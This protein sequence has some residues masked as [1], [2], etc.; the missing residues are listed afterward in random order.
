MVSLGQVT[1]GLLSFNFAL[2]VGIRDLDK[3][4]FTKWFDFM[5]QLIFA[6]APAVY[7]LETSHFKGGQKWSKNHLTFFTEVNLNP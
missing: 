6:T 3:F 7:N 4:K 1:L 2:T 5:L